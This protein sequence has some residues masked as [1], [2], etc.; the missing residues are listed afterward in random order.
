VI[1]RNHLLNLNTEHCGC[2]YTTGEPDM[3]RSGIYLGKGAERPAPAR[4]NRIEENEITGYQMKS[5]CIGIAPGILTDWN[6]VRRN[7]CR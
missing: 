7:R 2:Y 4:G 1:R 3:F 5:H 6:I